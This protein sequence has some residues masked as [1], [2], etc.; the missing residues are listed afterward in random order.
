MLLQKLYQNLLKSYA[1]EW[2]LVDHYKMIQIQRVR[3]KESGLGTMMM[4]QNEN[5][6][7]LLCSSFLDGWELVSSNIELKTPET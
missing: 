2:C 5:D 6:V 3:H 1:C 4:V 7:Y